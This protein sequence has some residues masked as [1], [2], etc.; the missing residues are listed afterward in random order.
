MNKFILC[1]ALILVSGC[2]SLPPEAEFFRRSLSYGN[3]DKAVEAVPYLDL[4]T[5]YD[6][7]TREKPKALHLAA[8]SG[9]ADV[10]LALI[11]HGADVNQKT[12]LGKTAIGGATLGGY[13]E[14]VKV[15]LDNG[16]VPREKDLE[17]I[18]KKRDGLKIAQY[19]QAAGYDIPLRIKQKLSGDSN[20]GYQWGKALA[21][22]VGAVAGGG[23]SLDSA[24]QASVISGIVLDSMGDTS[25]TSNLNNAVETS[26]ENNA[27]R[28]AASVSLPSSSNG[29][30][31]TATS[32]TLQNV[33]PSDT[34][35]NTQTAG[36]A[37]GPS[38][39]NP[40]P[41][42]LGSSNKCAP[43]TYYTLA[44]EQ[45]ERARLA[46]IIQSRLGNVPI[47][48]YKT[49]NQA[50]DDLHYALQD[51]RDSKLEACGINTENLG[52]STRVTIE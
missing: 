26:L 36:S 15:L 39:A 23:L 3:Y 18:G 11:E 16:A 42:S 21:L 6:D 38:I 41:N 29:E 9:S 12:H 50:R 1:S 33:N 28:A 8:A 40:T 35:R 47:T 5:I 44:E 25:G 22:G 10:V 30:E 7:G 51:W 32:P 2:A 14:V 43:G 13:S 19:Y 24:T 37:S 45:A 17:L 31:T 49:R 27:R 46:A 34:V 4:E 20:N 52:R 48:D